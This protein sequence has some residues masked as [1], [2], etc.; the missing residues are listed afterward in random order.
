[1]RMVL[2]YSILLALTGVFILVVRKLIDGVAEAPAVEGA[3]PS[4]VAHVG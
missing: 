2:A 4:P 1:M 3:V